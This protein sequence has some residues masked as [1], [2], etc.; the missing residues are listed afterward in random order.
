MA[1]LTRPSTASQTLNS[2]ERFK[3]IGITAIEVLPANKVKK[4]IKENNDRQKATKVHG[5][6]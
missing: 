6:A 1:S 4:T 2:F 5:N 3:G